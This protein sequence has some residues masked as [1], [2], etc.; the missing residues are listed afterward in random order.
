[1]IYTRI[2]TYSAILYNVSINQ[3]LNHF[4]VPHRYFEELF[5][6][7]YKS[8]QVQ[9]GDTY[10]WSGYGLR[11]ECRLI[12]YQDV[13]NDS[14]FIFDHVFSWV[15]LY[16]SGEGIT[17]LENIHNDVFGYSLQTLLSSPEF[18]KPITDNYK[19][20]RCDFAFDY[21]NYEGNEFE[22]LTKILLHADFDLNLSKNGRLYTGDAGGITYSVRCGRERTIYFGSPGSDR[23][24][25]IYD[26]KYQL[27]S[28]EGVWQSDKIPKAIIDN[29]KNIVSWYRIELQTRDAFAFRY[30]I[31]SGGDFRFV[32]G[33]IKAHFDVRTSD[34]KLLAPLHKIYRWAENT[35]IIQNANSSQVIN[36][37]DAAASY[38]ST[39]PVRKIQQLILLKGPNWFINLINKAVRS[40]ANS[41]N[42]DKRNYYQSRFNTELSLML[43]QEG[44]ELKPD[45][46]TPYG[47]LDDDGFYYL[48][49]LGGIDN[50]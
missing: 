19:I 42:R 39:I 46:S 34:G 4:D 38:V 32:M 16:I 36:E 6:N 20:T 37:L 49:T 47:Y 30:L 28:P 23:L 45:G 8:N 22:R 14:V 5:K 15:R 26:K 50:G 35:A 7:S 9:L 40:R 44:I 25:R 29:E 13:D 3:I 1:M 48:Y 21:V 12:E 43:E 18:Y 24:L 41:S 17:F 11:L 33:E 27:C 31:S 10:V 2:D